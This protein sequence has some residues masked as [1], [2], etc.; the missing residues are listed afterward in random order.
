[1]CDKQDFRGTRYIDSVTRVLEGL[2][3]VVLGGIRRNRARLQRPVEQC[4]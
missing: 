2:P 1:V 3:V 4:P